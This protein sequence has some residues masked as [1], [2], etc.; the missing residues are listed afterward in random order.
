MQDAAGTRIQQEEQYSYKTP[1][2]ISPTDIS[3]L[4]FIL[5]KFLDE[6]K[7]KVVL[8]D[9]AEYIITQNSYKSFLNLVHLINDKALVNNN[10][11]ILS[12]DPKTL[13]SIQV[14]N[15]EKEN[16]FRGDIRAGINII[17]EDASEQ[18][19]FY[20]AKL[21]EKGYDGICITRQ[22]PQTRGFLETL[23]GLS[24]ISKNLK[25]KIKSTPVYWL[26]TNINGSK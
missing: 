8:L 25:D 4:S 3:G 16:Y 20:F 11:V 9:G 24:H 10:H 1:E 15:I 6:G 7:K 22:Y 5:S 13:N 23:L 21:M 19:Y 2:H 12:L 18:A 17:N 26:T 14:A